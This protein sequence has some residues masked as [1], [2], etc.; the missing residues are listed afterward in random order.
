MSSTT[1]T[2]TK[3]TDSTT[4]DSSEKMNHFKLIRFIIISAAKLKLSDIALAT[5]CTIYHRFYK[6]CKFD[7]FDPYLVAT[8]CLFL[9]I[10]VEEQE[11]IKLR[12]IINVCYRTKHPHL[13]PLEL[14]EQYWSLR[15]SVTQNELFIARV[16]GFKL[17]FDH[18][19]QYLLQYLD[20]LCAW[21][22]QQDSLIPGVSWQ[23]LRDLLHT[24]I[25]LRYRP[26]EIA[27]AIIYFII[28]SYGIRVPYN[29]HAKVVWWKALYDKTNFD[30]IQE[31]ITDI[32]SVYEYED[33]ISDK[34]II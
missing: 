15:N 22:N 30:T 11:Q 19:H 34:L 28:T 29:D 24:D 1:P 25:L 26:Q 14:N 12:D 2:L 16:L 27:I 23:I 21:I 8:S 9:S 3:L 6:F 4:S 18:P 31:I 10:K 13:A 5:A 17:E 7:D 33:T 20:S 32:I